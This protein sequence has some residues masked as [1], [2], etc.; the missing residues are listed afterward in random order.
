MDRFFPSSKICSSCGNVKSD[1]KL[2]DRTYHCTECGLVIDRD[3]NASLNLRNEAV[4]STVTACCLGSSGEDESSH[5]TP[6]WAG[7]LLQ[8]SA[9]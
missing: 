9:V 3:L 7:N 5:E 4:K 6:D 2:S 8:P 1:L